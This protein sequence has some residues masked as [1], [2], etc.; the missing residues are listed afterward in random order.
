MNVHWS[1]GGRSTLRA[2][3]SEQNRYGPAKLRKP[4]TVPTTRTRLP[5]RLLA[6]KAAG[7]HDQ[8]TTEEFERL[9]G[10]RFT[11]RRR[12][13]LPGGMRTMYLV[14]PCG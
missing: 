6:N 12:E 13:M 7:I 4:A 11:V 1:D 3:S 2:V 5:R 10:G 14:A 8:Y 9:L